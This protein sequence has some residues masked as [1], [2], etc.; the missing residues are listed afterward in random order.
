MVVA[1]APSRG[2]RTHFGTSPYV[3]LLETSCSYHSS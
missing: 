1:V 3:D 2:A